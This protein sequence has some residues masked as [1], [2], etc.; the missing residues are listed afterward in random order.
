MLNFLQIVETLI[1]CILWHLIMVCTV[2][3]LLFYG[4][5][6]YSWLNNR[7]IH[8]NISSWKRVVNTRKCLRE[9]TPCTFLWSGC[10]LVDKKFPNHNLYCTLG[11]ENLHILLLLLFFS[12][13]IILIFQDMGMTI[14][15][16]GSFIASLN[17]Q[18]FLLK[19]GPKVYQLQ[20]ADY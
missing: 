6:D 16:F 13:Y 4:S 17:N 12:Q 9:H 2:C 1:R 15:D 3:Q 11:L 7:G 14:P 20:T 19:K 10:F 5:P 8:M 18:G